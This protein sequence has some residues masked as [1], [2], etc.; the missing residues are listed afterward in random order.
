MQHIDLRLLLIATVPSKA[1]HDIAKAT[2][3]SLLDSARSASP[4][5]AAHE[6]PIRLQPAKP[7][8]T[9]R[10]PTPPRN[11]RRSMPHK[12]IREN[13]AA[14]RTRI[15]RMRRP[16]RPLPCPQ[17]SARTYIAPIIPYEGR[18]AVHVDRMMA[19]TP[20]KIPLRNREARDRQPKYVITSVTELCVP[21][22]R[23]PSRWWS[24]SSIW[25]R[26]AALH[27][28]LRRALPTPR[29]STAIRAECRRFEYHGPN[30]LFHHFRHR[31]PASPIVVRHPS[32]GFHRPSRTA[33]TPP[34]TDVDI[35]ALPTGGMMPLL[36]V[37]ALTNESL[38]RTDR[39]HTAIIAFLCRRLPSAFPFAR[40][41]SLP[42]T[43][44]PFKERPGAS[45]RGVLAQRRNMDSSPAVITIK[46]AASN[47]G[48][49]VFAL[50]WPSA[51]GVHWPFRRADRPHEL[52]LDENF[53]C[54]SKI[55]SLRLHTKSLLHLNPKH[56]RIQSIQ[57][58]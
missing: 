8:S 32:S 9:Q 45:T 29:V 51:S 22:P 57:F 50:L 40:N 46:L 34:R 48:N 58:P 19:R 3:L 54:K 37:T 13:R 1:E 35:H 31:L 5:G 24:G 41:A 39:R 36:Q 43:S 28:L 44:A 12:T 47:D 15:S 52:E 33:S 42:T 4:S 10:R 25:H 6:D 2:A 30:Q 17:R 53:G 7:P 18:G 38:A 55:G 27:N 23:P 49:R 14:Q 11:Q 16:S 20:T 21:P 56:T 26:R